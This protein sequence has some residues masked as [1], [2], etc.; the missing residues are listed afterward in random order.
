[1]KWC[2]FFESVRCRKIWH[3]R[4][5]QRVQ[6]C[7]KRSRKKSMCTFKAPNLIYKKTSFAKKW[8][9]KSIS[10]PKIPFNS[11]KY[12]NKPMKLINL[13]F[14]QNET[15]FNSTRELNDYDHTLNCCTEWIWFKRHLRSDEDSVLFNDKNTQT[16]WRDNTEYKHK[17]HKL[18]KWSTRGNKYNWKFM[19]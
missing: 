15:M 11:T 2:F 17:N 1:M 13:Q 14:K 19:K 10:L 6:M 9:R 16:E 8:A 3:R 4:Y 18:H 5:G 7:R 12:E